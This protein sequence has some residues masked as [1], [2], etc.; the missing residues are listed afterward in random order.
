MN[1]YYTK[2]KKCSVQCLCLWYVLIGPLMIEKENISDYNGK[3]HFNTP[4]YS[5]E[6]ATTGCIVYCAEFFVHIMCYLSVL[7][8]FVQKSCEIT[9]RAIMES[10]S[11]FPEMCLFPVCVYCVFVRSE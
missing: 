10:S 3:T 11:V 8:I 1:A 4:E 6:E 5:H 7:N 9:Y 2:A